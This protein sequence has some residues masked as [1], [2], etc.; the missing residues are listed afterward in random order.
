MFG[1]FINWL[2]QKGHK[3]A[4]LNTFL[5]LSLSISGIA[6]WQ[7]KSKIELGKWLGLHPIYQNEIPGVFRKP[8]ASLWKL[9]KGWESNGA[10]FHE[11]IVP[12]W[13]ATMRLDTGQKQIDK[14]IAEIPKN[15]RTIT[16]I[17]ITATVPKIDRPTVRQEFEDCRLGADS[18]PDGALSTPAVRKPRYAPLAPTEPSEGCTTNS[19]L[20]GSIAGASLSFS[21]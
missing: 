13:E 16:E 11:T 2:R 20:A 15:E 7:I 5:F 18:S 17:A 3:I 14:V 21:I 12:F 10:H 9:F 4:V 8:H 1:L 6:T 19:D